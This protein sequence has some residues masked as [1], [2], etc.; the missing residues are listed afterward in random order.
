METYQHH[1]PTIDEVYKH[2]S[3]LTR[4]QAL[5]QERVTALSQ[6]TTGMLGMMRAMMETLEKS[7]V[8]EAAEL[9]LQD[10]GP[11]AAAAAGPLAAIHLTAPSAEAVPPARGIAEQQD[12]MLQT[13]KDNALAAQRMDMCLAKLD[14]VEELLREIRLETET[15]ARATQPIPVEMSGVGMSSLLATIE[16]ER[17]RVDEL[18]SGILNSEGV[19]RQRE[20]LLEVERNME[21]LRTQQ[22]RLSSTF[23]AHSAARAMPRASGRDAA[24]DTPDVVGLPRSLAAPAAPAALATLIALGLPVGVYEA[25]AFASF[26]A[27]DFQQRVHAGSE[28]ATCIRVSS[29]GIPAA[30]L[31]LALER[32]KAT[33]GS[34]AALVDRAEAIVRSNA[35]DSNSRGGGG[36]PSASSGQ[37]HVVKLAGFRELLRS[38]TRPR[39]ARPEQRLDEDDDAASAAQAYGIRNLC[40]HIIAATG[41][42][43]SQMPWFDQHA[44]D[45]FGDAAVAAEVL[46]PAVVASCSTVRGP[47]DHGMVRVADLLTTHPLAWALLHHE[48]GLAGRRA[49]DT[50]FQVA[51]GTTHRVASVEHWKHVF[52]EHR[53]ARSGRDDADV[54]AAMVAFL[55]RDIGVDSRL[56]SQAIRRRKGLE[57][58]DADSAS[59]G[60][61]SVTSPPSMTA[62]PIVT[63][64]RDDPNDGGDDGLGDGDS[65]DGI[66][67][68]FEDLARMH[69]SVREFDLMTRGRCA[70]P[71]C[72][73]Q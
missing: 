1:Q 7:Q 71:P 50:I 49:G 9:P 41:R 32:V 56:A 21:A 63:I 29:Q 72:I 58:A 2:H 51:P 35:G 36:V 43:S 42:F 46:Y 34:L 64:V 39:A 8:A 5:T 11:V 45:E 62:P 15:V 4:Q 59:A 12:E 67:T 25:C 48:F 69:D 70:A 14:T 33:A 31:A 30:S 47:Q 57:E 24:L 54:H 44:I 53:A 27:D 40:A 22:A 60:G 3:L 20:M 23:R 61:S 66:P 65:S 55:V 19:A 13:M 73:L 26:I 28:L 17:R 10:A 6:Q 68:Q 16:A 38:A 18:L 52:A 37:S